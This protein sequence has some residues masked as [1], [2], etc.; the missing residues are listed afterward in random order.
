MKCPNCG[1]QVEQ[2]DVF[3]GECGTKL[4]RQ[5]KSVT[6]A[7]KDIQK[8]DSN[9]QS[10]HS[11][12]A[13]SHHAIN[14]NSNASYEQS[15]SMFQGAPSNSM[16]QQNAST[17]N[18]SNSNFNHSQH[19]Q[20]QNNTNQQQFQNQQYQQQNQQFQQQP[21]GYQKQPNQ[22][23]EQAKEVTAESKGFFKSAFVDPDRE[24]KSIHTFSFKLLGSLLAIGLILIAIILFLAIPEEVSLFT[25]EAKIVFSI[26]FSLIILLAA[27]VGATFGI[28]RLVVVQAIP[29]KKVLSDFVFINS[30]TVATLLLSIILLIMEAYTFGTVIL[31]LS[32]VIL[33]TSGVYLI[34]KYS[35]I[36]HTR[37]SSF[38][39][40]IIYLIVIFILMRIF[41]EVT[42]SS[43]L[44][45]FNETKDSLFN[46]LF[47]GGS[48]Y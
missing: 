3:C 30:V 21:H 7:E 13:S 9:S 20:A 34:A 32:F 27:I 38:Y 11:T 43:I 23:S 14:S 42:F 16:N 37:F 4:E 40:M 10:H 41:G 17:E 29:F 36:N 19:Q 24:I 39:G 8:A 18:S 47:G 28:T 45:T 5:S 25:S 15:Q 33:V 2:D 31:I 6:A 12:H 35:G 48:T 1:H 44:E 46:S 22:F 26:I